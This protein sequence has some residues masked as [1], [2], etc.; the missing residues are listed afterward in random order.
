MQDDQFVSYTKRLV[1]AYGRREVFLGRSPVNQ[2]EQHATS[3]LCIVDEYSMNG[4]QPFL[5]TFSSHAC[6]A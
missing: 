4:L 2:M 3:D 5:E 1:A 6:I